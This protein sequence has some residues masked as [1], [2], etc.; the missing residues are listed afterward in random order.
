MF[1]PIIDVC[2]VMCKNIHMRTNI[3][4]NDDL[5]KEAARLTGLKTKK[6][7]VH[8]ALTLLVQHKNRRSILSLVGKVKLD[9]NYDYKRLRR[10]K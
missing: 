3:D 9:P 4:I 8:E 1:N 6:E 7:L 2:R 10:S 5:L